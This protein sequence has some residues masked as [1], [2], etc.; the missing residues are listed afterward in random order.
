MSAATWELIHAERARVADLVEGLSVVQWHTESLCAG[1]T[2]EDVVAHLTAAARTGTAAWVRSIVLAGFSPDRHNRRRLAAHRGATPE[3]T[4]EAFRTSVALTVAPTKD[5]AAWLGEVVVH[6][7][8]TA[9]PLGL[10]LVPDPVAVREVADF[11]AAKD[12]AVNSCTA[13]KGL[14][15]GA[16]D[17]DFHVGNGPFVRGP[18]LELVLAMAGRPQA[19]AALDG[20]G[21]DELARRIG[22]R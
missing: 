7:Q 3:E 16:T 13:V 20:D 14:T 10:T 5:H 8:D 1:W 2:V 4:A 12:F 21:V 15:L 18:L 9:R 22:R 11:F 19:L 6:G 17:A